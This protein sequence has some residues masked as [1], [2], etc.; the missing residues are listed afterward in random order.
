MPIPS[1]W[2]Q[3]LR[4]FVKQLKTATA[5]AERE[6]Y[7]GDRP[8][9]KFAP[10]EQA[11]SWK[12]YMEWLE[13]LQGSWCFRGQREASWTLDTSL[14][15]AVKVEY[16]T[17]NSSGCY[18]L[19]RETEQREL[20]FR[21]QQQAHSHVAHIPS[22]DDFGSWLA[23]M[24]H[25]GV[26]TR[27]LDWTRSPYVGLYFAVADE[28]NEACSAVWAIDL[29]W[30]TRR[31]R[32]LLSSEAS[33]PAGEDVTLGAKHINRVLRETKVPVIIQ[34]EPLRTSERMAAQQ[35]V[36]LCKLFHQ[37][38]FSQ[39]LMRMI[40]EPDVPDYPVLR[41]LS[42]ERNLRIEFLK[43]LR[44]MNIHSASLFPGIDGFARSLKL[45][46]EIKVKSAQAKAAG[47]AV[48]PLA[49]CGAG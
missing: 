42:I 18:H 14:D 17:A 28:P 19:D 38:T 31:A 2:L 40:I 5:A 33:R 22:F 20:F 27:L 7:L 49:A 30:L 34:I 39:I 47:L 45:D 10:I 35:G 15:R 13:E 24:Q 1:N 12:D 4:E 6:C 23:M 16:S 25:H 9:D 11:A 8:F 37:A 29:Q 41:K 48:D 32:E 36:L 21:F 44:E 3:E 26:P 43:R 46:L